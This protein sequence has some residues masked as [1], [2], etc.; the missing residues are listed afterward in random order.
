MVLAF[1]FGGCSPGGSDSKEPVAMQNTQVQFLGQ[2]DP[3][4]SEWLPNP[5]F[6]PGEFHW[7]KNLAVIVHEVAKSRNQLSD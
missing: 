7:Q 6:L 4:R 3:S 5:V 1:L 2:D